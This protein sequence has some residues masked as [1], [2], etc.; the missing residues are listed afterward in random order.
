M[1]YDASIIINGVSGKDQISHYL[2]EYVG[3]ESYD[4]MSLINLTLEYGLDDYAISV[5]KSENQEE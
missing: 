4:L 3:L 2:S 5:T 1:K